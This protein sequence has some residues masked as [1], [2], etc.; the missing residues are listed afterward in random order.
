MKT[1]E[2][3]TR[4]DI[5]GTFHII[6]SNIDGVKDYKFY[7]SRY[8]ANQA[9]DKAI[10]NFEILGQE[11][12][13]KTASFNNEVRTVYV[14]PDNGAAFLFLHD[15]GTWYDLRTD[16]TLEMVEVAFA[17]AKGD[18]DKCIAGLIERKFFAER[19]SG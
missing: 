17:E 12:V 5:D 16:A 1:L 15:F 11:F 2:L 14:S 6:R 8:E 13:I 7:T 4:T 19:V 9:F 10:E 3:L 18:I